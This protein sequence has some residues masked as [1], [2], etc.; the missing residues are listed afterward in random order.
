MHQVSRALLL[1]EGDAIS[2]SDLA[3][4]AS[5]AQAPIAERA[6]LVAGQTL[7]ATEKALL[8]NAL[9]QSAG[10]VSEAARLL[11]TTRM[12]MRYRM[13]KHGINA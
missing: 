9:K 6:E 11:G 13:A 10:N 1:G 12:T 5:V 4:P 8:E 3:L 2:A 7:N